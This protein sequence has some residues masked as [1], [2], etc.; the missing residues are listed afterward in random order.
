MKTRKEILSQP[1]V[2]TSDIKVL[3]G[4]SR[5]YAKK[6]YQ[7]CDEEESNKE[8]RAH[9]KKVPLQRAL[10]VAGVSYAFLKKQTN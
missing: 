7:I 4:G 1:L 6:I 3:L 10:Q 5:E 9:P 8:F 2:N